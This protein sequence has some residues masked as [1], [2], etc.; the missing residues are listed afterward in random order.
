MSEQKLSAKEHHRQAEE[1]RESDRHLEALKELDQAV[2]LY[3][4]DKDYQGICEALQSRVLTF[5]HLYFLSKDTAFAIIAQKEAE[6]SLEVAQQHSVGN[7]LGSCYFRLGEIAMIFDNFPQAIDWYQKALEDYQGSLSEK[8][9]YRY[10]LGEALYKNGQKEE[11]KKTILA[12]LDEIQRGAPEVDPFLV[13]VWESG[14]HMKLADLL[15]DDE[16]EE[17]RKH[18]DEAR[19]IADSDQRL[20]IRRRQIEE[21]G[22]SFRN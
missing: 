21:V 18:L 7:K 6:A 19:K 10:H 14:L 16:P 1:L 2:V 9:D 4:E 20:I 11:G 5:K 3:Q 12:G 13:H 22:K 15:R 17:A 8:G